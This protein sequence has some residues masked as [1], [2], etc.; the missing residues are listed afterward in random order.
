MGK[1]LPYKALSFTPTS[2]GLV[3]VR[4]VAACHRKLSTIILELVS[5]V[6]ACMCDHTYFILLVFEYTEKLGLV[7][8]LDGSPAMYKT[9]DLGTYIH[10][11]AVVRVASTA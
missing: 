7:V 8:A 5:L 3:C 11:C 9:D 2:V 4:Y 6:Y 10:T 1:L